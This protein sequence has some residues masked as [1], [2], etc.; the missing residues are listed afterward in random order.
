MSGEGGSESVHPPGQGA[1]T[2][3]IYH[4][5]EQ[6]QLS[7][8]PEFDEETIE[9]LDDS[10]KD[11]RRVL[12]RMRGALAAIEDKQSILDKAK[13]KVQEQ[14]EVVE[15]ANCELKARQERVIEVEGKLQR[16]KQV[17]SEL[18]RRHAQL[19]EQEA[20]AAATVQ[21]PEP[22]DPEQ[23]KRVVWNAAASLRSLG[24]HPQLEHVI[25]LLGGLFQQAESAESN[26][27]PPNPMQQQPMQPAVA[28]VADDAVGVAIPPTASEFPPL[29]HTLP[30]TNVAPV[31]SPC[32]QC[33][34]CICRCGQIP[35]PQRAEELRKEMDVDVKSKKRAF[36]EVQGSSTDETAG[37]ESGQPGPQTVDDAEVQQHRVEIKPEHVETEKG[38]FSAL[39]A[40]IPGVRDRSSRACP[41]GH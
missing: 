34:S 27:G 10:F 26:S 5:D 38:A 21:T 6:N 36:E 22:V 3:T 20:S 16:L 28:P 39:V 14:L 30:V 12:R 15:L 11:T 4:Q 19:A 13:G 1:Q 35:A 7:M 40:K 33:W 37:C 41:Y 18:A 2:F 23:A 8:E 25:S 17:H 31:I 29:Q 32:L 9:E 24:A